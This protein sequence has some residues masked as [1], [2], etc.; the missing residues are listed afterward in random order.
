MALRKQAL[1]D[2]ATKIGTDRSIGKHIVNFILTAASNEKTLSIDGA[3][4]EVRIPLTAT[5]RDRNNSQEIVVELSS[6]QDGGTV[7]IVLTS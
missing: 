2:A 5:I 6:G 3:M 7:H 1:T 4:N